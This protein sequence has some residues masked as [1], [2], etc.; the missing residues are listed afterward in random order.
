MQLTNR[1]LGEFMQ[2]AV[3]ARCAAVSVLLSAA[4]VAVMVMDV[5]A[6]AAPSAPLSYLDEVTATTVTVVAKPIVFAREYPALAVHA[7]DYIT[8]CAAQVNRSGRFSQYLVG[9]FWST[10][11]RRHSPKVTPESVARVTLLADDREITLLAAPATL[12]EAG[13]GHPPCKAPSPLVAPILY[14]TDGATLAYIA[15]AQRLIVKTTDEPDVEPYRLWTDTRAELREFA[16]A[17]N[18]RAR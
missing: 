6:A 4:L 9:F 3:V 12:A 10:I 15:S 13:M 2:R 14:A 16:D 18:L 17:V 7:R 1:S 8:L 5:A 11:D